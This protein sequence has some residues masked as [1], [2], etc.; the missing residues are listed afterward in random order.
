[1]AEKSKKT[2]ILSKSAFRIMLLGAAEG[3]PNEVTGYLAGRREW[4]DY[5]IFCAYPV[6]NSIRRPDHVEYKKNASIDRLWRLQE[7]WK[8]GSTQN[9]FIGGFH[10][11]VPSAFNGDFDPTLINQLSADKDADIDFIL[12]EMRKNKKSSWIEIIVNI[13]LKEISGGYPVNEHIY[14]RHRKLYM[15]A[16]AEPMQP[17]GA[18]EHYKVILSGYHLNRERKVTPLTVRLGKVEVARRGLEDCVLK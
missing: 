13:N 14:Y 1:M 17:G 4:R 5:T 16:H 8:K 18:H 12:R 10:S 2:L 7:L 9:S 15:N 6:L 11:H 3:W